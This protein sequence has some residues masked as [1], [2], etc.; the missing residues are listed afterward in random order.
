MD[1][2]KKKRN[3]FFVYLFL[4]YFIK[5]CIRIWNVLVFFF[6]LYKIVFYFFKVCFIYYLFIYKEKYL[7][8]K[9]LLEFKL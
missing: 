6:Y 3:K 4:C 9:L 2:K 7:I 8:V 1:L 5:F